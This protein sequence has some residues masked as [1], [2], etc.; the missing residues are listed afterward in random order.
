[1]QKKSCFRKVRAFVFASVCV[2]SFKGR[3]TFVQ[4]GLQFELYEICNEL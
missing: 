3:Y 1:M 4:F 2:C